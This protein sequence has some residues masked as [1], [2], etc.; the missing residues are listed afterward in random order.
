MEKSRKAGGPG[1][2]EIVR[3]YSEMFA[4]LRVDEDDAESIDL[5]MKHYAVGDGGVF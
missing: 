1:W 5:C 4:G 3:V 2:R